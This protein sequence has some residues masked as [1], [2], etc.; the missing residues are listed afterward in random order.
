MHKNATPMKR[1]FIKKAPSP[2]VRFWSVSFRRRKPALVASA[3]D[4]HA[5]PAHLSATNPETAGFGCDMP[6]A[7]TG[8]ATTQIDDKIYLT[9]SRP[10]SA[11]SGGGLSA[12]TKTDGCASFIC[13]LVRADFDHETPIAGYASQRETVHAT[14]P[15]GGHASS[16]EA[17]R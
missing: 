1:I 15:C 13:R 6:F 17:R 4:A 12:Q 10:W 5:I 9:T 3:A 11:A 16:A 14:G 7:I 2:I 8:P